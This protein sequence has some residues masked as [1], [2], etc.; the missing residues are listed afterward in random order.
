MHATT[1]EHKKGKRNLLGLFLKEMK[2]LFG[3]EKIGE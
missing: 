1:I 2:E 3:V